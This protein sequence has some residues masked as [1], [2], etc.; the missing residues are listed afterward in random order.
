MSVSTFRI[1][2]PLE[3]HA[4]VL[5]SSPHSGRTYPVSFAHAVDLQVLRQVEDTHVEA[6]FEHVPLQGAPLLAALMP[7]TFIDVNRD[8][9]DLDTSIIAGEWPLPVAPSEH[10]AQGAGLIWTSLGAEG[11]IYARKLS[12][13]EVLRR[14][15]E[16]WRPYHQELEARLAG[17]RQRFGAAWLVDCH[18]M[19]SRNGAGDLLPDFVLGD[20]NGT[21][22]DGDFTEFVTAVLAE[23]G[24]S[25][26]HNDPYRGVEI[27]RRHSD[28]AKGCHALQIEINRRLYMDERTR[29]RHAGFN[30]LKAHL[31]E[32]TDGIVAFAMDRIANRA[33]E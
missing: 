7:R 22:C 12:V 30:R 3:P 16:C 24:Y 8:V 2:E 28:P 14:I 21:T 18:S 17:F 1:T 11:D 5:F 32:L 15:Y 29:L 9:R 13:D 4:P 27:L 10:T 33:A 31:E 6:L 26:A 19:P 25:V 20:R 23:F